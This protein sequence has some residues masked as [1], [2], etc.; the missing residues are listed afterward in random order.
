MRQ[1]VVSSNTWVLYF[2]ARVASG[3][4]SDNHFLRVG[5]TAYWVW[6]EDYFPVTNPYTINLE[7]NYWGTTDT[8]LLDRW[9]Y[10]GYDDEDVH[11]WIDYQ[12][13]LDAPVQT[14]SATWGAVKS[15]FR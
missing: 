11:V 2:N 15:L 9:I 6:V 1:N 14:Q 7:N 5:D 4:V 10:D 13:M 3:E 8:A 12:P